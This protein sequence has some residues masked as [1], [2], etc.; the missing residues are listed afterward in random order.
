MAAHKQTFNH[1]ASTGSSFISRFRTG[2]S[3]P[4]SNMQDTHVG[5]AFMSLRI[6][7]LKLFHRASPASYGL[8][9]NG[10]HPQPPTALV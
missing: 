9:I 6:P 4:P 7:R 5:N 8:P 3:R 1:H 2:E 10:L